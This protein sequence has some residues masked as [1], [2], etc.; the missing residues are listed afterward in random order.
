M[1]L[2]HLD[3]AEEG[4][5]TV[6]LI[7]NEYK[8]EVYSI[9]LGV[10]RQLIQRD[11]FGA[12][13]WNEC[14]EEAF[15]TMQVIDEE[16][17]AGFIQASQVAIGVLSMLDAVPTRSSASTVAL[18]AASLSKAYCL[19]SIEYKIINNEFRVLLC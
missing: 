9:K 18:T 15:V 4:Q 19:I 6:L 16:M 17:I 8:I 13:L 3:E 11:E 14:K 1:K 12:I 10:F 7:V 5:C 2:I